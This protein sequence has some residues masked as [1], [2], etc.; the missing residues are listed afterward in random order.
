M[1]FW[2]SILGKVDADV[3][4][5]VVEGIFSDPMHQSKF[6][7]NNTSV[8]KQLVFSRVHAGDLLKWSPLSEKTD[9]LEE[10]ILSD[11]KYTSASRD[12]TP[13]H[14]NDAAYY[15]VVSE[16]VKE[17]IAELRTG[18]YPKLATEFEFLLSP[19]CKVTRK[20]LESIAILNA[21]EGIAGFTRGDEIL[22]Y[23]EQIAKSGTK[24][25][26]PGYL[27]EMER[28]VSDFVSWA[29]E[30]RKFPTKEEWFARIH[31]ALN[32]NSAGGPRATFE[33]NWDRTDVTFQGSD[34][35]L[36]FLSD[37]ERWI[38]EEEFNKALS[39]VQPGG[40]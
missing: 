4:M 11:I 38:S 7:K 3:M 14:F 40:S 34:K 5:E 23:K 29:K 31:T 27:P 35:T 30:N 21:I 9:P 32:S 24:P 1:G 37:P 33:F 2:N 12:G 26:N 36:V 28:Y 17:G 10:F 8:L 15:Q 6:I 16:K 22:S 19:S 39:L 13:V 20:K 25:I 18:G